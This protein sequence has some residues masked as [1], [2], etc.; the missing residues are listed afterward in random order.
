MAFRCWYLMVL[1]DRTLFEKVKTHTET[2]E[3]DTRFGISFHVIHFRVGCALRIARGPW[4]DEKCNIKSNIQIAHGIGVFSLMAHRNWCGTKPLAISDVRAHK[5]ASFIVCMDMS[6]P[7]I[8]VT[9]CV[10]GCVGVGGR[11]STGH[12]TILKGEVQWEG[13]ATTVEM[14][15]NSSSRSGLVVDFVVNKLWCGV[16]FF[17]V[18]VSSVEKGEVRCVAERLGRD[19]HTNGVRVMISGLAEGLFGSRVWLDFSRHCAVTRGD[20]VFGLKFM[21]CFYVTQFCDW[22]FVYTRCEYILNFKTIKENYWLTM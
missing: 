5:N 4:T 2:T 17:A 18:M 22:L 7:G 12:D 14:G 21:V 16:C 13:R 6:L 15:T 11:W 10:C 3:S 20:C 1:F 8:S 9:K 19:L